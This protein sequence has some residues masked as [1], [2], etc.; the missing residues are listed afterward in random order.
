[1]AHKRQVSLPALLRFCDRMG[2]SVLLEGLRAQRKR[3]HISTSMITRSLVAGFMFNVGSLLKM[4]KF[5]RK[6]PVRQALQC[7]RPGVASD[8]TVA[9]VLEVM[10]VGQVLS[11][12][13]WVADAFVRHG[14]GGCSFATARGRAGIVDGTA[15][16]GFFCSVVM[17]HGTIPLFHGVSRIPR[18][19]KELPVSLRLIA[20]VARRFTWMLADGLYACLSFFEL[21]ARLGVKGIV[22]TRSKTLCIVRQAQALFRAFPKGGPE[23]DYAAGFDAERGCLYQAWAAQNLSWGQAWDKCPLRFNV[24]R[25]EETYVKGSRKGHRLFHVISQDASL[26]AASGREAG[27]GRWGIESAFKAANAAVHTKRQLTRNPKVALLINAFEAIAFMI[28]SAFGEW[29]DKNEEHMRDLWDH[30]RLALGTL[31]DELWASLSPA[32]PESS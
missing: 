31:Q 17:E 13:R 20:K 19:G 23:V 14:L 4:D 24:I 26:G 30:G 8:T 28:L 5:F 11:C 16:G 10:D 21:C 12:V 2:V 18:L 9:R 22:K 15:W 1:M 27:H 29:L 6:E 3:P 32:E 25:V 7:R